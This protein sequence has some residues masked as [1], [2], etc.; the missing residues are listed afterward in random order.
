MTWCQCQWDLTIVAPW[1]IPLHSNRFHR[2]CWWYQ[3]HMST[4]ASHHAS[5]TVTSTVAFFR[6]RQLFIEVSH[7]FGV[8]ACACIT[9]PGLASCDAGSIVEFQRQWQSFGDVFGPGAGVTGSV[10]GDNGSATNGIVAF[11][12]STESFP[13]T[14]IGI[15][16]FWWHC[17]WLHYIPEVD[18][19][20]E[21]THEFLY[22][23]WCHDASTGFSWHLH[24]CQWHHC[25]SEGQKIV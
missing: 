4:L 23:C 14:K 15:V 12:R 21:V 10:S 25:I 19:H 8:S 17:L 2:F 22:H 3:Y 24:Y 5:I 20:L 11:L 1:M 9:V 16:W 6:S 18:D 13:C 7:D